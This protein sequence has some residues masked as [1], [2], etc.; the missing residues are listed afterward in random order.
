M[1]SLILSTDSWGVLQAQASTLVKSGMLPKE[2][3]TPEK[4][5]A[6]AMKGHE[7]GIPMMQAFAHIHVINGKPTMSAELMLAQIFKNCPGATISYD[8][9]TDAGCAI[10]ACRP[11]GKPS[12]FR[13]SIEDATKAGLL[14]NPTW[15]KYRRSMLRSRCI[16]EVARSMFP[17]AIAGVSYTPEE[18]GKEVTEEGEIIDVQQLKIGSESHTAPKPKE[19]F[20]SKNEVQMARLTGFL[21]TNKD[22]VATKAMI[23][24]VAYALEGKEITGKNIAL[25]IE[26]AVDIK[27]GAYDGPE[28]SS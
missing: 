6:I 7:L 27:E 5:I 17:D 20:S 11:G 9:N 15:G 22:I 21:A 24:C 8:E 28:K 25:A 3:N 10:T 18:L 2:I 19:I 1:N 13:F 23:D 14:N 16:S 12:Q 4:A 26:D